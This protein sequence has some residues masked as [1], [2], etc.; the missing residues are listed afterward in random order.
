MTELRCWSAGPGTPRKRAV[1]PFTHVIDAWLRAEPLLQATVMHVRLVEQYRFAGIYQRVT[2]LAGLHRRFDVVPSV[3]TQV[4]W[5]DDGSILAHVGI[6]KV[7]SFHMVL[8]YEP[9]RRGR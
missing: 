9:A 4:D 5:G 7:Y 3:Q 1:A 6:A 8:S 2:L